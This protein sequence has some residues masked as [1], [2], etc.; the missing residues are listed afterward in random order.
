MEKWLTQK[1][2]RDATGRWKEKKNVVFEVF[3]MGSVMMSA[4]SIWP[5]FESRDRHW[6][7]FSGFDST[8]AEL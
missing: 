1:K 2:G 7:Y 3:R 6:S 5:A 4:K 8:N